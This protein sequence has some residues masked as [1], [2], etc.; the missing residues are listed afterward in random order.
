MCFCAALKSQVEAS[1]V[2]TKDV[3]EKAGWVCVDGKNT[4]EDGEKREQCCILT[5]G[6]ALGLLLGDQRIVYDS[7]LEATGRCACIQITAFLLSYGY[8]GHYSATPSWPGR[9]RC[10]DNG[11]QGR[12]VRPSPFLVLA[13]RYA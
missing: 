1:S 10:I 11:L 2:E 9:L 3:L 8:L 13:L 6:S 7:K 5:E 4:E 12:R